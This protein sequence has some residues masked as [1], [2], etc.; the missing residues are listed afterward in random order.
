MTCAWTP[1]YQ[2]GAHDLLS[3][4]SDS[5]PQSKKK[6]MNKTPDI[7]TN[8]WHSAVKEK[9]APVVE[10]WCHMIGDNPRFCATIVALSLACL[11]PFRVLKTFRFW[12]S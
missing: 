6:S 3:F 5:L 8:F 9:C 7:V 2:L 1:A 10:G 4:L 11:K 12:A